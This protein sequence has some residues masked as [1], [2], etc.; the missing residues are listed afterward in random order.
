MSC[1]SSRFPV[2][3]SRKLKSWRC[4]LQT[5]RLKASALPSSTLSTSCLSV[6]VGFKPFHSYRR[7]RERKSRSEHKNNGVCSQAPRPAMGGSARSNGKPVTG[8]GAGYT[9]RV[10][11]TNGL[12]GGRI[13][14]KGL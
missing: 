1:A 5:R 6:S 13:K 7:E 12:L 8:T 9:A 2:K 14:T 10:K 11:K 3:R 4:H